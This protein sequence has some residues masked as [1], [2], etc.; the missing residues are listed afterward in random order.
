MTVARRLRI[1]LGLASPLFIVGGVMLLTVGQD[2][3]PSW[4]G[5]GYVRAVEEVV[6]DARRRAQRRAGDGDGDGD[7]A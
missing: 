1:A 3:P 6:V 7:V 5:R 2:S 4:A